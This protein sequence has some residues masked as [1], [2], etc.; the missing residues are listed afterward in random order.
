MG[1]IKTNIYAASI[2]MQ[3][4]WVTTV[5]NSDW[6]KVQNNPEEQK[7]EM[8]KILD[9][10][11]ETGINTVMFQ[12]RTQGDALYKSNINPWSS[13]LTGVQGKDPGYDPLQFVIQEAHK[14]G[15][16]VHVWLNPY[17]ITTEGTDLSKLYSTHPAKLHPNWVIQYKNSKGNLALCYNPEL[18]EV[19]KHISDTVLEIVKN[20]GVDGINFDDYFYPNNPLPSGETREGTIANNRR[21]HITNMIS[22]VNSVIKST[23]PN[24]KFG[25]SPRGIWK[26]KSSDAIGSNTNGNE[27]Y[28]SD[29]ADTRMWVKNNMVDYIVPQIYWETEN[30]AADYETLVKWWADVANGTNVD[31]YIG[32][33]IYK[34][35]VAI[36]INTQ[37]EINK[38]YP[39]VDGSSYYT[40]LDILNNRQDCRNKIKTFL[41]NNKLTDISGHWAESTI[42]EFVTKGYIAG[43]EDNTFKPD[44]SITRAEFVKIVNKVFGFTEIGTENFDD[45]QSSNWFY[46]DIC[47]GVTVGYINGK[48]EN[49]FDPNAPIT[50]EEVASI[51]TSIKNNKDSNLDKLLLFKDSND[52]S[53]WAKSSVEGSIENKYLGGY[54]D[55][56]MRPKSKMTRAESVVTLSRLK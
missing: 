44:N 5:Y 18:E 11:K 21:Q 27:S 41:A 50:R 32:Q 19:K 13:V 51:I 10:L 20:Y 26:N 33:G 47:I 37:L 30:T 38:K 6:P 34:D 14:R 16:K 43:Y 7:Q 23:N 17:R 55:N 35:E 45:V 54:S 42:N 48:S 8:I 25:V 56:T 4:A 9:T 40:T 52:V 15:M 3:A 49:K 24:V 31:L 39:E 2:D 53:S 46:H 12:A 1:G 28:Y 36:Q 22:R 29:Y